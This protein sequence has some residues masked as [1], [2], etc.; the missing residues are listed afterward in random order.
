MVDMGGFKVQRVMDHAHSAI[1]PREKN[2]HVKIP[3]LHTFKKR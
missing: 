2:P 1:E 3:P